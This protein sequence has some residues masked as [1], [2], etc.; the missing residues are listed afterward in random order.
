MLWKM[1][2]T[3]SNYQGEYAPPP[4]RITTALIGPAGG[5]QGLWLAKLIT[6]RKFHCVAFMKAAIPTS[7][8]TRGL[9]H[10]CIETI[11]LALFLQQE[12]RVQQAQGAFAPRAALQLAARF[13]SRSCIA[14][15]P[16]D[17]LHKPC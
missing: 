2:G 7:K 17:L 12:H 13:L 11:G 5:I 8:L 15:V 14:I 10:Y 3:S 4:A 6:E 1:S 16:R 9:L